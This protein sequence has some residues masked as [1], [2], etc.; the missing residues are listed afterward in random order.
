MGRGR[1]SARGQIG[2]DEHRRSKCPPP[3]THTHPEQCMHVNKEGTSKVIL[4]GQINTNLGVIQQ[5]QI[6]LENQ[7]Q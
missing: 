1:G 7:K 2:T 4:V 3:P 6:R 5:P